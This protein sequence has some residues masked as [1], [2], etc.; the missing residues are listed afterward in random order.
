M[1]I[2]VGLMCGALASFTLLDTAAKWAMRHGVPPLETVWLRYVGATALIFATAAPSHWRALI[3]SNRPWMQALRSALLFGSTLLNFLALQSLQLAETM[4]ILFSMPLIVALASG[5][6]LG[7][8]VGPRRLIAILIGFCGVLVVAQ[9]GGEGFKPAMALSLAGAFCYSFYILMTRALARVDE[10]RTAL[11]HSNLVGVLA[12]APTMPAVWV[13]PQS[14]G[15]GV[16]LFVVAAFGAFG[17][18]LII[19]AHRRA[20]AGALAPFVYVQLLFMIAAGWIFFGDEPGPSTLAGAGIV[21]ASG[22]YLLARER[23]VKGK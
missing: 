11:V 3:R 17:H 1:L 14:M 21:V 15:A 2:G 12:L 18:L 16:A 10:P 23:K 7:E 6:L 8:W 13:W 5:P 22:L 9:P 4:S 19:L 20:S